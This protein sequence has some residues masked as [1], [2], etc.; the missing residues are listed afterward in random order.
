MADLESILAG[1]DMSEYYDRFLQA[2]FDSWSILCEITEEDLEALAVERGHRRKLQKEIARSHQLTQS[3]SPTSAYQAIPRSHDAGSS[4]PLAAPGKR[5]YRRHPKPDLNAPRRP[6]AAY[7]MFSNHVREEVNGQSMPFSEISKLVG[8]KWQALPPAEKEEWKELAAVP[9]EK[10]KQDLATYQQTDEYRKY[11]QYLAEFRAAQS[12]RQNEG[13]G[14]GQGQVSPGQGVREGT[15]RR[16]SSGSDA[17]PITPVSTSA[18][19]PSLP[20]NTRQ[21]ELAIAAGNTEHKRSASKVA[22]SRAKNPTRTS[23]AA[24]ARGPRVTQ[25]MF[26][27]E[28]LASLYGSRLQ[29]RFR[30]LKQDITVLKHFRTLR[31]DPQ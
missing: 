3:Q 15:L 26:V 7:V 18:P 1:L 23:S 22:I 20:Q 30:G 16:R 14:P 12:A 25:G 17:D 2:G 24:I 9:W 28:S 31:D 6:Y 8:E 5:N 11:E 29:H 19:V 13:Q 10:Y 4:A 21:I 27:V